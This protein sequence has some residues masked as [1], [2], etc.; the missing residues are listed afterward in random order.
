MSLDLLVG[1]ANIVSFGH[2]A[3]FGLGAYGASMVIV[4][5]GGGL[6][7][8]LLTGMLTSG[9]LAFG[10]GTLTLY[11]RDIYFTITTLVVAEIFHT[12]VLAW[13]A[14]TGGENGLSFT[15]PP[16]TLF[17]LGGIDMMDANHFYFFV[18]I[19]TMGSLLLCRRMMSSPF[20]RILQ[21]IRDN[22]D[23]TQAIGFDVRRYKVMVFVVSG[24]LAGLSGGLYA[25]FNRYA[26]PDFLH[27]IISGEAVIWTLIGGIGTLFGPIIGV[28]F[29]IALVDVLSSWIDNYL[30]IVGIMFVIAVIYLPKGMVGTIQERFF[31]GHRD[32]AEAAQDSVPQH[33]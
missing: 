24:L 26:N 10:V 23:R 2:A 14:F 18:L 25:L 22:E 1:Y 33:E 16:L 32:G 6:W 21:G 29:V 8:A 19:I 5:L 30:I 7:M 13:T 9:L 4:K 12:I 11:L 31:T 20:G 17:G 3:L 28:G 27:F 15:V